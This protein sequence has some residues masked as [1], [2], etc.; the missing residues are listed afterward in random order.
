VLE[1]SPEPTLSTG[2]RTPATRLLTALEAVR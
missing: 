2:T 1:T